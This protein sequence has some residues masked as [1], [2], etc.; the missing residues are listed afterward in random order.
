[1]TKVS[2]KRILQRAGNDLPRQGRPLAET[3]SVRVLSQAPQGQDRAGDSPNVIAG[4]LETKLRLALARTQD[5]PNAAS[6]QTAHDAIRLA[7]E[8]RH[9]LPAVPVTPYAEPP[10]KPR[11]AAG[12][13]RNLLAVSLSALVVGVAVQQ[14]GTYWGGFGG[15]DAGA[16]Q[17]PAQ[18]FQA[19]TPTAKDDGKPVETGYAIQAMAQQSGA[20]NETAAAGK[21]TAPAAG[22]EKG[23][24]P[25][26]SPGAKAAAIFQRD[27]EEAVKLF[28][29][30]QP[31]PATTAAVSAPPP[32]PVPALPSA[33]T[34]TAALPDA[35]AAP[36]P[37]AT[38]APSAPLAGLAR[39]AEE[40]LFQRA[41]GLMKRGDVTGA[42]LLFEH[43]ARAGS[44]V[45]AFALAQSYDAG[46]L[47]KMNVRG[48]TPDQQ[49]ADYWYRRAAELGTGQR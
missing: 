24:V 48:L 16:E 42:R 35:D 4:E 39:G 12:I 21:D 33:G 49:R 40:Q 34:R 22:E 2:W 23:A 30:K 13:T 1:M 41:A 8:A 3:P 7:G 32:A 36:K 44:A 31:A 27:M 17:Q 5:T 38:P 28:E 11:A 45:G 14:I 19:A 10:A 15:E 26:D 46:Y 25:A 9:S 47:Q 6:D 18:S 43:L 29:S 20:S 37:A